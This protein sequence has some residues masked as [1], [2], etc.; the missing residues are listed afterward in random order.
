MKVKIQAQIDSAMAELRDVEK[1]MQRLAL[2]QAR[3]NER[4]ST[5]KDVLA[6]IP[7]DPQP[8]RRRRNARGRTL[9]T[10]W[11]HVLWMMMQE[12]PDGADYDTLHDMARRAGLGI[13]KENL[14]GHM[15]N[16]KSAG[17]VDAPSPGKFI[18][19][20][21]G[22][23]L[24][25]EMKNAAPEGAASKGAVTGRGEVFP[26]DNPSGSIPDAST[27]TSDWSSPWDDTD[28]EIPF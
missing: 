17:Y 3:L 4:V 20:D 27:D 9:K 21:E 1:Q 8:A 24:A 25:L 16:Y 23:S 15:G 22:K 13:K 12:A 10:E 11:R 6:E 5:L 14:R 28:D 26:A 18:V 19:T 2:T 7:D